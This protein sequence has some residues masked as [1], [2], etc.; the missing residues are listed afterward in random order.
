[1]SKLQQASCKLQVDQDEQK[2]GSLRDKK[3]ASLIAD[4]RSDGAM[5][6][7]ILWHVATPIPRWHLPV[8]LGSA[9]VSLVH[10]LTHSYTKTGYVV[11]ENVVP[12]SV[13]DLMGL[14]M[15][16]DAQRLVGSGF[17]PPQPE[18]GAF[19]NG[20]IQL[21]PPRCAP[22]VHED[23]LANP[24]IEQLVAGVLLL[25][26][27]ATDMCC[28]C[29]CHLCGTGVPAAALPPRVAPRVTAVQL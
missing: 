17:W 28:C 23:V 27:T 19:G 6:D 14:P 3:C 18:R 8:C 13:C 7:T 21:G 24:I 20:H 12:A 4:I 26:C 15:H 25:L 29:C 10:S 11:I 1:M 22:W 9:C 5:P 2:E 16:A